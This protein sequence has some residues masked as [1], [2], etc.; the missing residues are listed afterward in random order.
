MDTVQ[1]EWRAM[2]G[3]HYILHTRDL[4]HVEFIRGR[5]QHAIVV[6]AGSPIIVMEFRAGFR[7]QPTMVIGRWRGKRT[8]RVVAFNWMWAWASHTMPT[9]DGRP[10]VETISGAAA[11][12]EKRPRG[13]P[14]G[15]DRYARV[16]HG[17]PMQQYERHEWAGRRELWCWLRGGGKY[18]HL[19]G[20][21]LLH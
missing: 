1:N 6:C 9:R 17:A 18:H 10:V 2:D 13:H 16:T 8:S 12:E 15:E 3:S 5:F 4:S 20:W 11:E 7:F 14:H 21:E 19:T